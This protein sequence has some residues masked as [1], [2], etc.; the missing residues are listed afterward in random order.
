MTQV[1]TQANTIT[2]GHHESLDH[3][4]TPLVSIDQM[5]DKKWDTLGEYP[6]KIQSL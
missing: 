5:T 2:A 3:R 4:L 1:K 6:I